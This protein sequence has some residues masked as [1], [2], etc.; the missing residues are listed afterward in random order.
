M[1]GMRTGVWATGM[2]SLARAMEM[3][4]QPNLRRLARRRSLQQLRTVS[5]RWLERH[6]ELIEASA[7]GL[8]RVGTEQ[9]D[10]CGGSARWRGFA[11]GFPASAGCGRSMTVV[12]GFDGPPME[13]LDELGEALLTAG[14]GRLKNERADGGPIRQFWVALTGQELVE[15]VASDSSARLR[16]VVYPEWRPNSALS[17]PADMESTPPWGRSP[18]SPRMSVSCVSRGQERRVEPADHLER[19]RRA[20]RNYLLLETS[21]V[22]QWALED[23]AL[24]ARDH[25]VTVRISLNYY[26]NPN[27]K[28]RPHRIPRYWLP[29]SARW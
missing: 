24:A 29:T 13:R 1:P 16:R 5:A 11:P 3:R 9:W 7:P 17:R 6:F 22:Q 21:E 28:A 2:K 8:Q 15:R 26:S 18:L 10:W 19:A 23:R 25:A 4:R 20:P 27:A 12:Y 14:W